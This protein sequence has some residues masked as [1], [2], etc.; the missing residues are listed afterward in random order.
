MNSEVLR[1]ILKL[2][3]AMCAYLPWAMAEIARLAPRG[4][5]CIARSHRGAQGHKAASIEET[6]KGEK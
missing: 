5:V 4:L 1:E 2:N 3:T 6:R